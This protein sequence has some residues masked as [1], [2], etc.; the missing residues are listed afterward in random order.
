ME[1]PSHILDHDTGSRTEPASRSSPR[2]AA[3]ARGRDRTEGS[4][5][6]RTADGLASALGWF[7]I[8]L[9]LAQIAAPRGMA[10]LI[11]VRDDRRSATIMRTIGMREIASGIGILSQHRRRPGWVWSRVAGDVMDLALLGNALNGRT[12]ERNRTVAATATVLG[13]TALDVICGQQLERNGG[14]TGEA[15]A[16]RRSK[17]EVTASVTINRS[18]EEV[19]GFWHQLDNLPQFMRHLESV[20]VLDAQRSHWTAKAPAGK[21]VAWDAVITQD[22]PNELIG[23]RSAENAQVRNEGTVRFTPA[24][25]GRGTE[26]TVTLRYDPPAGAVGAALSK[27]FLEEPTKQIPDDLRRLKQVLEIGEVMLSDATVRPGRHPAQPDEEM[28]QEV[29]R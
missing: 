8:G 26:V 19:Y 23:W 13:V 27:L 20:R 21:T 5:D 22:R 1:T 11:G 28:E 15:E 12:T 6:R 2:A 7:S 3:R 17:S 25:G 4:R 29:D 24:P 9:G 16:R 10:R 18:P 14:E